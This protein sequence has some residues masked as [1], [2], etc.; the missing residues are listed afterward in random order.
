MYP[1]KHL[2]IK[3][4]KAFPILCVLAREITEQAFK[5]KAVFSP[6]LKR[7]HPLAAAVATLHVCYEM[8]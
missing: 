2:C 4:N 8:S 6:K 7:W 3:Q 1:S 5:Q